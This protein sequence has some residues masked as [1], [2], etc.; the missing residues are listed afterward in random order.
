MTA[1]LRW[2][3]NPWHLLLMLVV[4]CACIG[5]ELVARGEEPSVG[6]RQLAVD[7]FGIEGPPP[8]GTVAPLDLFSRGP[9]PTADC[10]L[11]PRLSR[12]GLVEPVYRDARPR[13]VLWSP[14]WC[15]VCTANAHVVGSGDERL[16]V[17]V[18]K[19]DETTFPA[20][21]QAFANGT[22]PAGSTLAGQQRG[23]PVWQIERTDGSGGWLF[24]PHARTLDDLVAI[25]QL[26]PG[27]PLP[28]STYPTRPSE[29]P[30]KP[31]AM[32]ERASAVRWPWSGGKRR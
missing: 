5:C 18:R 19:G 30:P 28:D 14:T 29:T 4:A 12:S 26:K 3:V 2:N 27:E 24:A 11:P 8:S 22:F 13:A 10:P 1:N 7:L 20:E 15:L 16:R 17:D 6:S 31:V 32:V 9:L 25:G 23:W 21:V